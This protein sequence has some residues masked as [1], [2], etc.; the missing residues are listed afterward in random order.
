MFAQREM[1]DLVVVNGRARGIIVPQ[2]DDGPD[3][4]ARRRRGLP[5][6]GR[7]RHGLLPLDQRR[8]LERHRRVA[9][10]QARRVLRQSV[11]HADPSDVHS[12]LGRAPVEADADVRVAAQRRPRLGAEERRTTSGIRTTFPKP[13]ATT[14][15]SASTRA[16][17]TSCRATSRRATRRPCATR[18]A[19]SA[20]AAWRCISISATPSSASAAT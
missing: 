8:E 16:S 11:L 10:A 1:L 5:R 9:R 13:S 3:R 2:S 19:A 4:A 14:T 12:G 6:H 20:R 15:S 18:A 17:A 7:L